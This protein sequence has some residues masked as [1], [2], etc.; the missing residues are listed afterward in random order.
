MNPL[1]LSITFFYYSIDKK[2]LIAFGLEK[3]RNK[4]T[5]HSYRI[6]C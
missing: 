4:K 6:F 3:N 1:N 5:H 2:I